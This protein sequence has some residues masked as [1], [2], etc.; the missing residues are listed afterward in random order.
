MGGG[1]GKTGIFLS[2]PQSAQGAASKVLV[3]TGIAKQALGSQA[4]RNGN[5]GLPTGTE[6]LQAGPHMPLCPS[7]R[8]RCLLL[9]KNIYIDVSSSYIY[10]CVYIHYKDKNLLYR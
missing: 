9:L 6:Q 3:C 7:V 8:D 5:S 2:L 4:L 10:M 1:T